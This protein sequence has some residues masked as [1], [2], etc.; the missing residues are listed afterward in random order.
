MITNRISKVSSMCCNHNESFQIRTYKHHCA[1]KLH[2]KLQNIKALDRAIFNLHIKINA[3]YDDEYKTLIQHIANRDGDIKHLK[4]LVN[5]KKA[6][7]VDLQDVLF[8]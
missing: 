2:N 8:K 3:P 7:E 5:L 6:W 4:R 1:Q